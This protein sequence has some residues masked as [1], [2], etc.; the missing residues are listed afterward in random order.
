VN[1]NNYC[2]EVDVSSD[3]YNFFA[4]CESVRNTFNIK[5]KRNTSKNPFLWRKFGLELGGE[6]VGVTSVFCLVAWALIDSSINLG[7]SWELHSSAVHNWEDRELLLW[8]GL[9]KLSDGGV[10][11]GSF[12]LETE[13]ISTLFAWWKI[14]LPI[15]FLKNV[16]LD[17]KLVEL[18]FF[19]SGVDLLNGSQE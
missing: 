3:E 9:F 19:L 7:G 13:D 14:C 2:F 8:S 12:D 18:L 11:S 15:E 1:V 4:C 5:N 16:S 6:N 17:G 10:P